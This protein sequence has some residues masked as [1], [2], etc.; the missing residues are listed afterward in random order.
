MPN[1]ILTLKARVVSRNI[2]FAPESGG[3]GCFWLGVSGQVSL[4]LFE[5]FRAPLNFI[6]ILKKMKVEFSCI[7]KNLITNGDVGYFQ[8]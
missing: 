8:I 7:E 2:S 6:C 1:V 4:K 5:Y 3:R